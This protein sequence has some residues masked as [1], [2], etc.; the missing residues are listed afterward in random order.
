MMTFLSFVHTVTK[1]NP[2]YLLF[3][4]PCALTIDCMYETLQSQVFATSSDY[5][6]NLQKELQ[7]CHELVRLNMEVE[8]ESQK[9]T[10]IE[11]SL[12]LNTKLGTWSCCLT[13][14]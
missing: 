9:L 2:Y 5:D 13:Q 8:Q 3:G 14:Q 6:C 4:A 11:N 10:T 12:E 7:L 1:Y